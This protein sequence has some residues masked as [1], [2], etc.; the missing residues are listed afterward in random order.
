[1]RRGLFLIPGHPVEGGEEVTGR[2]GEGQRVV[3]NKLH[4]I[5]TLGLT[6][7]VRLLEGFLGLLQ[8]L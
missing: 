7:F 2:A 8:R 1:M 3:R 6:T 4:G 5:F